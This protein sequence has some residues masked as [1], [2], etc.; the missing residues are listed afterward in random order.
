MVPSNLDKGNGNVSSP[1]DIIRHE[2]RL[3][4]HRRVPSDYETASTLTMSM[5]RTNRPR[6]IIGPDGDSELITRGNLT[7]AF[8]HMLMV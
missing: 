1:M 2:E 3:S 5:A 7:L 8:S 6:Q 4:S